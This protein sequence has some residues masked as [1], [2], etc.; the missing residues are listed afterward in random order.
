M[1]SENLRK[2]INDSSKT[3]KWIAGT[4]LAV[5]AVSLGTVLI[6][7]LLKPEEK[8]SSESSKES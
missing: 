4:L 8:E 6:L 3:G 5:M 2:K 1:L 7:N